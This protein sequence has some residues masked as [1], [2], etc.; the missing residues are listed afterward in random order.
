MSKGLIIAA[1][2]LAASVT[3]ASAADLKMPV[4]APPIVDPPYSWAGFYLGG[5]VGYSWGRASTDQFDVVTRQDTI[6]AFRID[7]GAEVNQVPGLNV[8]FPLLGPITTVASGTSGRANVNGFIGGGQ[9]GYNWQFD[10]WVIGLEGDIQGSAERGSFLTCGFNCALGDTLGA[11]NTRLE[12]FG[13]VRPRVGFLPLD[14]ML[15]Y[16]TGGLAFGEYD[17]S[18]VSGFVGGPLLA[19][20]SRATRAGFAVGGGVEGLVDRHWSLKLEYL[21]MDLGSSS[22]NLGAVTTVAAFPQITVGD[23]RF[24][25]VPATT[26]TGTASVR[27]RFTDQILRFGFNYHL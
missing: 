12:W 4:K 25:L 14:R 11:A 5:N 8:A 2:L 3:A 18:Y 6:R 21:Y 1:G 13:T 20:A 17:N 23:G 7:T 16:A 10:R 22:T 15:L 24:F 27:T 9:A 26:T 19:G